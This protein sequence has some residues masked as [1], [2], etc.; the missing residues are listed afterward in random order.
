M[1]SYL[2]YVL[3]A[4]SLWATRGHFEPKGI[5]GLA[6]AWALAAFPNR[7]KVPPWLP[8]AFSL[9]FS[10]WILRD[11]RLLYV[12]PKWEKHLRG[13][14]LLASVGYLLQP[15]WR[16]VGLGLA[17]AGL[18]DIDLFIPLA[19]PDPK[20]DVFVA[21]KEA[22][23]FFLQGKPV[24]SGGYSEIYG[25]RYGYEP[26][27]NYWPGVLSYLVPFQSLTGD[28]RWGLVAAHLISVGILFRWVSLSVAL[29]WLSF[30]VVPFVLEQSWNEPL[31]A[32]LLF[33]FYLCA[34][35]KKM[36]WAAVFLGILLGSKQYLIPLGLLS[37]LWIY[38]QHGKQ[39]FLRVSAISL[40]VATLLLLPFLIREPVGLVHTTI[41]KVLQFPYREDS[42]NFTTFLTLCG[43][44]V[45]NPLRYL[46]LVGVFGWTIYKIYQVPDEK[47]WAWS[48]FFF[49]F[50][51]FTFGNHAFCNYYYWVAG[52][53]TLHLALLPKPLS[54]S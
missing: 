40:G 44:G 49:Y 25:G 1:S 8:W 14:A 15:K 38:R 19:S 32:M 42:L 31:L 41:T 51:L 13:L 4:W 22:I 45:L 5:A 47:T 52:L 35:R 36:D 48:S 20:I 12:L 34:S 6:V 17:L 46:V 3:L 27:F 11:M 21:S 2:A 30:P 24:Y 39:K 9:F 16:A 50:T 7:G 23:Q 43:L 29:L 54:R 18:I 33:L 37:L 10:Y 28:F 53:A 26:G